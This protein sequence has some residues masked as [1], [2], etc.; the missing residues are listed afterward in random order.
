MMKLLLCAL[1]IYMLDIFFGAMFL[2]RVSRKRR[3][4]YFIAAVC[5]HTA[6]N[7]AGIAA[8][9]FI[10]GFTLFFVFSMLMYKIS[11][12]K[13]FVYTST[14]YVVFACGREM[15]FEMLYRFLTNSFPW[16]NKIFSLAG[17]SVVY[18]AESLLAFLFLLYLRKYMKKIEIGEDSRFDWYL[19]LIPI[20]SVFILLSFIYIDF[21]DEMHLQILM[22]CG[23]FFLYFFNAAAFIALARFR[24]VM[25]R[26]QIA[27]LSLVKA[28]MEKENFEKVKE[29]NESY[30]KNIHD[31]RLLFYQFKRLALSE[32]DKMIIDLVDGWEENI[33]RA[34]ENKL[35]TGDAIVNSLLSRCYDNAQEKKIDINI[36]VE[37]GLDL[38]FIRD[39]DKISMFGNLLDN[40]IEAA[41]K[42]EEDNRKIKLKMFMG[43]NYFFILQIENTWTKKLRTNGRKLFSTKRN[44]ASHGLGMKIVRELAQKYGGTL[45]WEEQGEWFI[46]TLMIAR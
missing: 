40:A 43:N 1:E 24:Q 37:N 34:S 17:G 16:M 46:T 26:M 8:L 7:L 45:D 12:K 10:G 13:A 2:K 3:S 20:Y 27:E 28:D 23:A 36:F 6:I 11:V 9:N 29:A 35:Y 4:V 21:P 38:S 25:K 15:A 32:E 31:V 42:C 5:I 44:S 22:C 33:E 19:M 18:I 39:V 14:Y 30:Q 41:E